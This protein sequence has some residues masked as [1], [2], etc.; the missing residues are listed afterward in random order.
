MKL[1]Q[2]G[3]T[4]VLSSRFVSHWYHEALSDSR[5]DDEAM[6]R[7]DDHNHHISRRFSCVPNGML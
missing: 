3:Y 2:T 4:V 6:I 7:L 5:G 1:L